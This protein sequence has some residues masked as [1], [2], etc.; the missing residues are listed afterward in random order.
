MNLK[1]QSSLNCILRLL[2][3]CGLI[4][5]S[6]ACSSGEG[7]LSLTTWGEAF[8]E[9]KIPASEVADGW[10]ITFHKFLIVLG[11]LQI[12]SKDGTQGPSY[13]DLRL[14]D[15]HKKGPHSWASGKKLKAGTWDA[16]TYKVVPAT[17]DTV[18]GNAL[19]TDLQFMKEKAY[20]IYLE[21]S[22]TKGSVTKKFSWGFKTSTTYSNCKPQNPS[23][24]A[25]STATFQMTIHADHFF[26]D[27]LEN[28]DAKVRFDAIAAADKNNDGEVTLAELAAITGT[29]FAS[30]DHYGV[31]RFSK[32]KDLKA[33]VT[34][35]SQT[36]GHIDG[37]G[38]CDVRL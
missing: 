38:H 6:F 18:K 7:T 1:S 31:G 32:V 12:A 8:I 14:F 4:V 23:I 29:A 27:D 37:E 30:L 2:C 19:D 26:Y 34:Q 24:Q 16:L 17:R 11:G 33:F 10:Q 35:L 21:G 5:S 9:D 3:V 25:N 15:L 13:P 28:P 22:A 20:A 36:L